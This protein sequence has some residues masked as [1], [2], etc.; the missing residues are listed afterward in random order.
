[1]VESNGCM[2]F[3]STSYHRSTLIITIKRII[4]FVSKQSQIQS[5]WYCLPTT[6]Y[7]LRPSIRQLKNTLVFQSLTTHG[8]KPFT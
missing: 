7:V 1:M 2:D 8:P 3:F 4:H 6:V 5:C